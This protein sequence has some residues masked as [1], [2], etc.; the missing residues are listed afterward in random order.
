MANLLSLPSF[1]QNRLLLYG[2]TSTALTASLLLNVAATKT[3]FYSA[4]IAI[5]NS[6]GAVMVSQT[7]L[8]PHRRRRGSVQRRIGKA[9]GKKRGRAISFLPELT[10]SSPPLLP[11]SSSLFLPLTL[12]F[13]LNQILANFCLFVSLMIGITLQRIFFGRLRTI[14]VEVSSSS[15]ADLLFFSLTADQLMFLPLQHL[16]DR[17]WY[18]LTESILALTMFR[19]VRGCSSFDLRHLL[20]PLPPLFS[21]SSSFRSLLRSSPSSLSSSPHREDFDA[22]F[23]VMFGLLLFLKCF[24]WIAADRVEWVSLELLL[25]VA[26]SAGRFRFLLLRPS[27]TL[28]QYLILTVLSSA[29]LPLRWI[30]SLLLA[31]LSPSTFDSSSSSSSSSRPT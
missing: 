20:P 1:T 14:E 11:S 19:F 28:Y 9:G 7:S 8:N 31:L 12:C 26:C 22:P 6:S 18:F 10:S 21:F 3:G 4:A 30:N 27:Y 5:S 2:A 13:A 23:I 17:S 25:V 29:F 15:F 24:H 16:Y